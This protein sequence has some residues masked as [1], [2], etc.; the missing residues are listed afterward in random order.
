MKDI[1]NLVTFYKRRQ[2]IQLKE[3]I[4]IYTIFW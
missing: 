4:K 1:N 3:R 2:I